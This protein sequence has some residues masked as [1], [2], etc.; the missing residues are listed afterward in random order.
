MNACALIASAWL[1]KASH[2]VKADMNKKKK[3]HEHTFWQTMM[4][5]QAMISLL[6]GQTCDIGW[7]P[8]GGRRAY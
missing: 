2:C 5:E 1:T 7:E 4:F 3:R 6:N 8:Y